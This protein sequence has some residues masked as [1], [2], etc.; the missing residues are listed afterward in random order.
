MTSQLDTI[1]SDALDTVT[2]GLKN[3]VT[4]AII[5]EPRPGLLGWLGMTTTRTIAVTPGQAQR[6]WNGY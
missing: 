3:L 2:G 5:H 6:L 4:R 1:N